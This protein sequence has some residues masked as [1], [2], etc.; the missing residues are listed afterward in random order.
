[1]PTSA[2]LSRHARAMIHSAAEHGYAWS[3]ICDAVQLTPQQV[4]A[5]QFGGRDFRR[6]SREIKLLMADEFCGFTRAPCPIGTFV[7][8]CEHA[9]RGETVGEALQRAFDLYASR[10]DDI[11][12]ELKRRGDIASVQMELSGSSAGRELLYEWWFLIWPHFASWLAGEHVAVVAVDFPHAPSAPADE[13]A[14]A[15]SGSCRFG[16]PSA[17]L[18]LAERHL[19]WPVRRRS[20]ELGSFMAPQH[21]DLLIGARGFKAQ[22][23]QWLRQQ[24]A[25]TQALPSIETAAAHYHLGSQTLRRRLQAEWTSY[26]L[27]KDEVRREAALKYLESEELSI[28]EVSIRAGYAEVNGLTRALK[29]WAG[30]SPSRY[31]D[32]AHYRGG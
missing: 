28:G 11:R 9:L 24:L 10:T 5:A 31:R 25:T 15:L 23:R 4:Q 27:V 12:F 20:E 16:Q 6:I 14:E 21:D 1:M 18:L 7:D 13:Y 32:D 19:Q 22:L 30:I 2:L 3:D 8:M 26:R 17:R 29:S